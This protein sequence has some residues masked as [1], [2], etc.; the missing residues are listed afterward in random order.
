MPF[1]RKLDCIAYKIKQNR[2]NFNL[3][4]KIDAN[5]THFFI[6]RKLLYQFFKEKGRATKSQ[7]ATLLGVSNDTAL[8]EI[9]VLMQAGLVRKKGTGKSTVYHLTEKE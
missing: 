4:R 7:S 8:R 2:A 1:L 5:A 6:D 3:R 9:K